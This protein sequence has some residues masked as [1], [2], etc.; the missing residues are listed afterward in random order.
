MLMEL[1]GGWAND[2]SP[3]FRVKAMC[4]SDDPFLINK[5]SVADGNS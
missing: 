2:G 4:G 5:S 1:P 3:C